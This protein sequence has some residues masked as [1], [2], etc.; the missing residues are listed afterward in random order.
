MAARQRHTRLYSILEIGIVALALFLYFFIY[1]PKEKLDA[2]WQQTMHRGQ[3]AL[4]NGDFSEARSDFQLSSVFAEKHKRGQLDVA[5]AQDRLADAELGLHNYQDALE[6]DKRTQ[7]VFEKYQSRWEGPYAD[8]LAKVA[9]TYAQVGS[10]QEAEARYK[11][12][13]ALHE[14][15]FGSE[16]L[17]VVPTLESMAYFYYD[18]DQDAIAEPL[19][20]KALSI[21]QARLGPKDSRTGW[22]MSMLSL[23]CD[24]EGK[25]V[26]AEGLARAALG[27]LQVGRSLQSY[28]VASTLNRLGLALDGEGRRREAEIAF[29]KA[30][31]IR[32]NLSGAQSPDLVVILH[33]LARVYAEEGKQQDAARVRKRAEDISASHPQQQ[34]HFQ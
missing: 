1:R 17:Q 29:D 34:A 30:L 9:T 27:I 33:N 8:Y 23:V 4:D 14:K 18:R 16:S 5:L 32:Q 19:A 15:T 11:Q 24:G 7:P 6:L 28:D 3:V 10:Y 2:E 26:E 21:C 13:L 22:A 12:A 31:A 20:R 25:F